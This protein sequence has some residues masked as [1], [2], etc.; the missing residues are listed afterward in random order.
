M[1]DC[2]DAA[3]GRSRTEAIAV[4]K[5][6]LSEIRIRA[7]R[8]LGELL[9]EQKAGGAFS[10]GRK[11][12]EKEHLDPLV[13]SALTGNSP[14]GRNVSPQSGM[15]RPGRAARRSHRDGR[16]PTTQGCLD[17]HGHYL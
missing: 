6:T 7:E 15:Q 12:S 8:R 10:R 1:Q 2:T 9:A 13:T 5:S 16:E 17:G 14:C 3:A 11:C 4:L